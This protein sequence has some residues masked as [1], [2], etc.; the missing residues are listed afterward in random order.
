MNHYQ[1]ITRYLDNAREILSTKAKKEGQEYKDIKY[2]Q[3]ASGTAYNAALM[4]A[5]EYLRKKEGTKFSKPQSI[6]EY[7]IRLRKHNR[8]MLSYLNEAYDT[9]H[10]AGYYHGTPSVRTIKDGLDATQKMLAMVA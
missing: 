5:D 10:L 9:L 1:E 6:D 2:V 7:R 8:T 4:I 3:M